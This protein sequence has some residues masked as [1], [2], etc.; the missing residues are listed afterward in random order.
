MGLL[1]ENDP[2]MRWY[3][4]HTRRWI[5]RDGIWRTVCKYYYFLLIKLILCYWYWYIMFVC[6]MFCVL[7][8]CHNQLEHMH[9]LSSINDSTFSMEDVKDIIAK[10]LQQFEEL[11]RVTEPAGARVQ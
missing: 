2:Y 8:K 5:N 6:I 3:S 9:H 1:S 7:L 11:D 10:L 4:R